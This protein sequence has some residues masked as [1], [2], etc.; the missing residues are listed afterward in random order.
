MGRTLIINVE[1]NSELIQF[2]AKIAEEN[3]IVIATF[4][5]IGALKSAKI[6]FYNQEKHDY[7]SIPIET[8]HEM[9]SCIGNISIKDGK[10]F[11]HAHVVL[12]NEA[13]NVKAGHLLEGIVFASEVYLTELK[14]LKLDRKHDEI[15]GL[16]LWNR[17]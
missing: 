8:P 14:G 10:P 11:I 12:A 3:K 7:H 9:V 17:E 15:T 2:L 13:G 1:H 4:T 16:S 5:A 6:A